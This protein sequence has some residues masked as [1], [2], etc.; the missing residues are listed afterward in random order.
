MAKVISV[1]D[2]VPERLYEPFNGVDEARY[3]A[4]APDNKNSDVKEDVV[5]QEVPPLEF[6]VE[7]ARQEEAQAG[8]GEA[9][10]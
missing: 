3:G 1:R 8:A 5:P 2:V 9:P 4:N 6:Q 7:E 10:S